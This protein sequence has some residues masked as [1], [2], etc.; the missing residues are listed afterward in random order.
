MDPIWLLVLL[1]IA[2]ASGWFAS[3]RN[4]LHLRKRDRL[5]SVY[6]RGINFLVNEQ[7]DKAIETFLTT[8]EGDGETV[9]IHL[10]L[11]SLFRKRGEIARATRIHENLLL[12]NDLT[13]E[14]KM[15]ALFELGQDYYAAG[16]FDRA[17][18]FFNDLRK[19]SRYAEPANEHLLSIY[20]QEKEWDKCIS[21]AYKLSKVSENNYSPIIAHYHCELAELAMTEGRYKVAA[22]FINE[23]ISID[24][25]CVRAI[26]QLGR[27][28]V[29]HGD[30]Q[31]AIKTWRMVEQKQPEYVLEIVD[32]VSESYM[33][34][35]QDDELQAFLKINAETIP[36]VHLAVAYVDL[37]ETRRN[38]KSAESFLT[39]WIRKYPSLYGLH[40]LIL[41]K[42]SGNVSK[43]QSK[44]FELVK[45]M[46]QRTIES[47]RNYE[48]SDCGFSMRSLYWQCPGCK[49][50]NTIGYKDSRQLSSESLGIDLDG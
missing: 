22:S 23:A 41:L 38:F 40:R 33:H 34:L 6:L 2:A 20:E 8:L 16:L 4:N 44:D 47:Q 15:H 17:E 19:D 49:N 50:W 7:H 48:C 11:G 24:N 5:S 14:H 10:A 32:L 27:L 3:Q 9:E 13:E 28:K 25:Q 18:R 31:G 21:V 36:D 39:N 12:R 26:L 45:K 35:Q 30:H 29:I 42:L 46:V 37:L 1:P 43:E